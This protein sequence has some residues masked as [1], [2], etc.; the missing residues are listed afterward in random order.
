[1]SAGAQH[2][3]SLPEGESWLVGALSDAAEGYRRKGSVLA[4]VGGRGGAGASV[5]AAAVAVRAAAD[6]DPVLLVDCDPL[7]GGLDL[8]LGA[9]DAAGPRW[10]E[11]TLAAAG[12]RPPRCARPCPHHRSGRRPPATAC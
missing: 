11:L 2:V 5:L 12:C 4:V 6:G 7:G 8:V 9:E 10:P 3:I 1:M